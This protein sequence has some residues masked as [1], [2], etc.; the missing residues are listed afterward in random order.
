MPSL[1]DL[2]IA[3]RQRSGGMPTAGEALS[4]MSRGPGLLGPPEPPG[5]PSILGPQPLPSPEPAQPQQGGPQVQG[6]LSQSQR[7]PVRADQRAP[8]PTGARKLEPGPGEEGLSF[9]GRLFAGD[10]TPGE[11]QALSK[12]E[13]DQLLSR[14]LLSAGL[15]MLGAN[16]PG[17]SFGQVLARGI[18]GARQDVTR[19]AGALLD[20]RNAQIRLARRSQVFE[21]PELSELEKWQ[22]VRRISAKEGDTEAVEVATDIITN[23]REREQGEA[24]RTFRVVNGQ[25]VWVDQ[26]NGQVFNMEGE[27]IAEIPTAPRDEAER[28]DRINQLSDDY[29]KATGDL[30]GTLRQAETAMG[31][32]EQMNNAAAD[33]TRII[34]LT[35]LRDPGSVVRPSEARATKA[36]GG[37]SDQLQTLWNRVAA[38]G[39]LGADIRQM[40]DDEIRRLRAQRAQQL[41]ELNQFWTE[42]AQAAGVDPRFVVRPVTARGGGGTSGGGGSGASSAADPFAG[43]PPSEGGS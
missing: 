28:L 41:Q 14:G 17:T 18:M 25:G 35:K 37:A 31:P 9:F 4:G 33:Q 23:L 30:W 2:A 19:T 15:R 1:L 29:E 22:E 40:L 39:E 21:N 34:A 5:P 36:I 8:Q 20:E 26:E 3:G 38:G 13:Q 12:Q 10:L 27:Q 6:R 24:E 42:R 7:G 16:A 32:P 11:R 43:P